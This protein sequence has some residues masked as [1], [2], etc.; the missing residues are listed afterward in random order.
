MGINS[1]LFGLVRGLW[2]VREGI[3]GPISKEGRLG[4][5]QHL[6]YLQQQHIKMK[7]TIKN[8]APATTGVATKRR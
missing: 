8:P 7:S 6:Q 4:R 2:K 3:S 1:E 5:L